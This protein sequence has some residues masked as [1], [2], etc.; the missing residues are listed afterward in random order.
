MAGNGA[1]GEKPSAEAPKGN[2]AAKG[3]KEAAKSYVLDDEALR[4][5][6]DGREGDILEQIGIAWREGRPHIKCRLPGHKDDNPSFRWD[7]EKRRAFCTCDEHALSVFDIVMKIKGES[8]PEAKVRIAQLL[9]RS[10]L[11]VTTGGKHDVRWHLNPP[12]SERDE[13]LPRDY[14]AYRLAVTP[15]EVLLPTTRAVGWT[16]LG[17]YERGAEREGHSEKVGDY[18]CCVFSIVDPDGHVGGFRIYVAPGGQG[19][20][21]LPRHANGK[22]R[23]PKKAL[24][25]ED[26]ALPG[27]CVLWGNASAAHR[28]IVCE[29]IETGAAIAT[30]HREEIAAGSTCVAAAI[31]SPWL[32]RGWRPWPT[33]ELVIVVADRDEDPERGEK[34]SFREGQKAAEWLAGKLVAK[35]LQVAIALPGAPGTDC[36][37][38]NVWETGRASAVTALIASARTW[39]PKKGNGNDPRM[40]NPSAEPEADFGGADQVELDNAGREG[41]APRQGSETGAGF[42]EFTD[43]LAG[44]I[45][46]PMFP[47][48]LLPPPFDAFV[49]DIAGRMQVPPDFA[50]IPLLIQAATML[51]RSFRLQPKRHDVRWRERACL[52]GMVIAPSGSR[53]TPA[54]DE[55]LAPIRSMQ[56][57][58][59]RSYQDAMAEW[60]KLS[61]DEQQE[62]EKP[63]GGHILVN[64]ATVEGLLPLMNASN[65]TDMR[66]ILFYRD[67]LLGWYRGM[68]Q[69]K[70]GGAGN[71][72]QF[73]IECYNGGSHSKYRSDPTRNVWAE[74]LYLSICGSF[75]PGVLKE[76]F[77]DGAVDGLLARFQL[78]VYPRP[79][80]NVDVVDR[81]PNV[82]AADVV[83]ARLHEMHDLRMLDD[84]GA[85]NVL[86]FDGEAYSVFMRWLAQHQNRINLG[87][88]TPIAAHLAKYPG[89]FV[90]LA[91]VLHFMRHGKRAPTEVGSETASAV[92]EVIDGYLEPHARH[93]YGDLEADPARPGAERIAQW[94]RTT[95]RTEPIRIRDIRRNA[96]REFTH[97]NR[98]KLER[99]IRSALDLL[100]AYGWV[101]AADK[102]S[103]VKGGRPT[104]DYIVNPSAI[105]SALGG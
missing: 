77:R 93:I 5:A 66:G 31:S 90:R 94:I 92:R 54:Q 3:A 13:S 69:Y 8:F 67:E 40:D 47:T 38:L 74:D 16:K 35:G 9:G 23:D 41:F 84:T 68:N 43:I 97:E 59:S 18:P 63:V 7:P 62:T 86:R 102:A 72:R 57:E 53:K 10:D 65:N 52:W 89:T 14:L 24:P 95:K 55:V 91:L 6:L 27:H 76:T 105:G 22:K 64:E 44:D 42:A 87:E 60:K 15:T 81:S 50:A 80:V 20:A 46:V 2:G 12:A 78:A 19:K 36:D 98:E 26:K 45:V 29:G 71:D 56:A 58:Y 32:K 17:Y 104:T 82:G 37:A 1:E 101:R 34:G 39:A 28:M 51:G 85:A 75:Q 73:Y 88:L 61:R 70:S 33:V 99:A 48:H 30:S 25:R 11:I 79:L 4:G 103:S 49:A 96:W 100:E 83:S 21:E